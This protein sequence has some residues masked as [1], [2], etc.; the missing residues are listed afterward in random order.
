MFVTDDDVCSIT[1]DLEIPRTPILLQSS[2][3][4]MKSSFWCHFFLINF[5]STL[6]YS[7]IRLKLG[8]YSDSVMGERC[9]ASKHVIYKGQEV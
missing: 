7:S 6:K 8:K 1:Y 4:A 2:W 3:L 9:P 5:L